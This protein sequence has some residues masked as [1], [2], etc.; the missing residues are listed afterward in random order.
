MAEQNNNEEKPKIIVDD[1]WKSQAQAEKEKLAQEVEGSAAAPAGAEGAPGQQQELP[2]ASF[3]TLVNSLATQAL[4]ALGGYADPRTGRRLVDLDLAKFHID[5]LA[6]LKEK[7][8]G[9]L[10]DEQAKLLDQATYEAKMAFVQ[11]AQRASQMSQQQADG[12]PAEGPGPAGPDL[13]T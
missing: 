3:E 11:I 10:T 1:D 9:N 2:P 13:G 5:T 12:G 8:E 4:M 7:T 6:V